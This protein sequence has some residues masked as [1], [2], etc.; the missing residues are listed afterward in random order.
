MKIYIYKTYEEWFDDKPTEVLEGE[1][2]SVY[3]GVFVIDT[4]IDYKNYRQVL[5]LKNN[6]AIIY[7]LPQGFL[8][9]AK[10]I[11]VYSNV[12]SWQNST[13][14]ITFKGEVC[15]DQCGDSHIVFVTED[16]FKQCISLD[17]IYAVT[18]ER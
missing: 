17:G 9:Y 18:Y 15:E 12:A 14:E 4:V 16:G 13:P 10:E 6:F 7:V 2:N 3:N 8:C 11:N 5:S 1:V